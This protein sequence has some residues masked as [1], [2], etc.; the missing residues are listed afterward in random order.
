LRDQSR[1]AH[2]CATKSPQFCHLF[3]LCRPSILGVRV[4]GSNDDGGGRA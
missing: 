3:D 2:R 4:A 1:L